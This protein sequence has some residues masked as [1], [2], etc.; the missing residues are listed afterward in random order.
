MNDNW[1]SRLQSKTVRAVILAA[2]ISV[3]N[4]VI[5]VSGHPLDIETIK[6]WSDVGLQ[7]FGEGVTLG[8]LWKAYQGRMKADTEIK[9]LPWLD[10]FKTLTKKKE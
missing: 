6:F 8:L 10:E 2:I 3:A 9:P 5:A 4:A 1:K 7:L